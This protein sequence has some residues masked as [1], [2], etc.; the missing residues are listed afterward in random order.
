MHRRQSALEA[1]SGSLPRAYAGILAVRKKQHTTLSF[2]PEPEHDPHLNI[3]IPR[4]RGLVP[5]LWHSPLNPGYFG[6][7]LLKISVVLL[8]FFFREGVNGPE[9]PGYQP[10]PIPSEPSCDL[11][12]VK[13]RS[14]NSM[15]SALEGRLQRPGKT[16]E[17]ESPHQ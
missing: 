13:E 14:N 4:N 3:R 15:S 12:P 1:E 7:H 16:R 5:D 8:C 2:Y 11:E 17:H 6:K 9:M 10:V